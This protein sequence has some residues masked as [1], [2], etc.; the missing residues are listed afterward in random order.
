MIISNEFKLTVTYFT[1]SPPGTGKS[2]LAKAA[3]NEGGG[4]AFLLVK[5]RS[6]H[7]MGWVV[8]NSNQTTFQT[9]S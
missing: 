2:M 3:A 1:Y 8:R 6:H 4:G 5:C 7:K 9:G